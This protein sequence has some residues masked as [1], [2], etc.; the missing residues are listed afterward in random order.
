MTFHPHGV[1][2]LRA[3]NNRLRLFVV[4]HR[5]EGEEV[6]IYNYDDDKLTAEYIESIR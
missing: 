2:M 6:A 4:N 3:K 1:S 5:P